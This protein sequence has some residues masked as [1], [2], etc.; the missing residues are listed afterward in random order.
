MIAII[1]KRIH[2][3]K[4]FNEQHTIVKVVKK[5]ENNKVV[6]HVSEKVYSHNECHVM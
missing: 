5:G 1:W 2:Q 4:S 6:F 3:G